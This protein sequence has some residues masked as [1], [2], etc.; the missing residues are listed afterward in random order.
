MEEKL[1]VVFKVVLLREKDEH[2][3]LSISLVG[4]EGEREEEV[5][6]GGGG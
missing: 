2:V 3:M 5:G 1:E 4:I 6:I